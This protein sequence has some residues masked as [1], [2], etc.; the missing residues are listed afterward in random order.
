[1]SVTVGTYL[2]IDEPERLRFTW[3]WESGGLGSETIVTIEL[4][5]RGNGTR[6]NFRH[7]LFD[8]EELRDEH[9]T[10]W[11]ASFDRLVELLPEF[12]S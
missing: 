4:E 6:M 5:E 11:A 10:G 9:N 3:N 8:T 2:E 7:E 1:M 12:G